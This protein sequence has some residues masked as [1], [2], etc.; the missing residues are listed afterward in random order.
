MTGNL[1]LFN[2]PY[3]VL[4]QFTGE[5]DNLSRFAIPSD[6]Y[7]AGRLDKDSEGLLLLTNSGALQA[8]ISHPRFKM[9]KHYWVQ[10]EGKISESSLVQFRQ[11]IALKDGKTRPAQA[12]PIQPNV[13]ERIL[14]FASANLFQINGL[15]S[16]S[17]KGKTVRSEE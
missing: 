10:I 15:K 8:Q 17:A 14:P 16:L 11:G 12:K 2:K 9:R 3:G 4:S 7:V 6:Y 5:A 1:I 13:P